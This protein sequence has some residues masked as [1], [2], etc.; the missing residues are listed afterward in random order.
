MGRDTLVSGDFSAHLYVDQNRDSQPLHHFIVTA[1]D[2]P[3]ILAWGQ[4]RS[5]D[6]AKKSAMDCMRE[7][8][9]RN[10]VKAA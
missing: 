1:T 2:S 8:N 9:Q 5:S 7:F 3:R 10:A 4:E 6:A